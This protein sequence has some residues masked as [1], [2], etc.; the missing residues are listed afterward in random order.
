MAHDRVEWLGEYF[1]AL[2]ESRPATAMIWGEMRGGRVRGPQEQTPGLLTQ[3]KQ[4]T[5]LQRGSL[6]QGL[7]EDTGSEIWLSGRLVLV[8]PNP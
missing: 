6:V 8:F 5:W 1:W 7:E 4:E 2:L 3:T